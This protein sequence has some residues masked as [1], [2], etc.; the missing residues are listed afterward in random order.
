MSLF[1][2]LILF[3]F[4]SSFQMNISIDYNSNGFLFCQDL[5]IGTSFVQVSVGILYQVN[6]DACKADSGKFQVIIM[7]SSIGHI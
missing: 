7:R 6:L 1:L 3:T 5:F 2:F 4:L